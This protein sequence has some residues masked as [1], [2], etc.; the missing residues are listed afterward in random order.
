VQPSNDC[1]EAECS[2]CGERIIYRAKEKPKVVTCNVYVRGK[3]DRI[4]HFHPEHYKDQH[5]DPMQVAS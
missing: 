5:G 2:G 1:P 3:W 4:E